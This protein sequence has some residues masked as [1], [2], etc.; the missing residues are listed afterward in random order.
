MLQVMYMM[1]NGSL[2]Y[3]KAKELINIVKAPLI[4][5]NIKGILRRQRSF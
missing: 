5:E 2:T 3:K 1:E 4:K